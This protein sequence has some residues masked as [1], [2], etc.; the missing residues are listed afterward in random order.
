MAGVSAKSIKNRIRSMESTRQI[1]RAMELVASSKLRKAQNQAITTRPYYTCLYETINRIAS[2]AGELD[3]KFLG[4]NAEG[5]V[6]YI[7][8]AGDRGLSGGYNNNVLKL[9]PDR[10]EAVLP[11]G[12]KAVEYCAARSM[13]MISQV[14][15]SAEKLT[16]DDCMEI[17]SELCRGYLS[18]QY[19][20]IYLLFTNFVSVL[21]QTP[22]SLQLLPLERVGGKKTESDMLYEPDPETVLS[23]IIPQYLGGV[24]YG[25]LCESRASEQAA[26]RSAMDSA[27]QNADTMIEDLSLELNRARQAAITRE[28]T[29]IV[30]GV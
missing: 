2:S 3:S 24:I 9:L 17:A 20:R 26:R 8:I 6:G 28:I 29:E 15:V 1:T 12:K 19:S 11:I 13:E 27:T 30:A 16:S 10:P 23:A 21:T 5:K 25:A 22:A 14:Y 18:G 7:V 4:G